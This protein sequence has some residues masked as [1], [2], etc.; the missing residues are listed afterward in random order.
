MG[1]WVTGGVSDREP[2]GFLRLALKTLATRNELLWC[3]IG[4]GQ[5]AVHERMD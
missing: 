5:R 1:G 3:V 2:G 4:R